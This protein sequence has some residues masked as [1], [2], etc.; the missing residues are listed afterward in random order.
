MTETSSGK[1]PSTLS[2]FLTP[3]ES[4]VS[5][6]GELSRLM[7]DTKSL[8]ALTLLKTRI[9]NLEVG[10][11][12]IGIAEALETM[13]LVSVTFYPLQY[14]LADQQSTGPNLPVS[15]IL[16]QTL[17]QNFVAIAPIGPVFD[18]NQ[19]PIIPVSNVFENI[20]QML[21]DLDIKSP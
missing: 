4:K 19:A 14:A 20:K 11:I 21:A 8:L 5:V 1:I 10:Q 2:V 6:L 3:K 9:Y 13:R 17:F 7:G 15:D 12:T 18:V 16:A